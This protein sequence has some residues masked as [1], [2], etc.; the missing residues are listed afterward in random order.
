MPSLRDQ[1]LINDA[2]TAPFTAARA[3]LRPGR[4][5]DQAVALFSPYTEAKE[6]YPEVRQALRD[7][8]DKSREREIAA[9]IHI[10]N[11]L[12][13]NAIET[14]EGAIERIEDV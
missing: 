14:I 2:I 12:E 3:L 6:K 4:A 7:L 10:N 13:G 11:R 8:I 5:Y 1:L 9:Y